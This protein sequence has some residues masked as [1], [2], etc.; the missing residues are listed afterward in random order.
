MTQTFMRFLHFH[1]TKDYI[2]YLKC[3]DAEQQ[4]ASN[5]YLHMT[6]T[7]FFDLGSKVGRRHAVCNLL[8]LVKFWEKQW[9]R[10]VQDEEETDGGEEDI[11]GGEEDMGG[12]EEDMGSDY[13]VNEAVSGGNDDNINRD[14]LMGY[15]RDSEMNADNYNDEDNGP[16]VSKRKRRSS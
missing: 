6:E 4:R 12:G 5:A 2:K 16:K 13:A 10:K 3:T 11:G 14:D 9:E 8:G 1:R 15:E 7:E